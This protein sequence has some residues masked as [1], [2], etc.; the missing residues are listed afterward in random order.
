MHLMTQVRRIGFR[1]GF[2]A[3]LTVAMLVPGACPAQVPGNG[4]VEVV[5]IVPHGKDVN[6]LVLSQDGQLVLTGSDDKTANLWLARS[7]QLI[8]SFDHGSEVRGVGF[9]PDGKRIL[10]A[11]SDGAIKLWDAATA[12]VITTFIGHGAVSLNKYAMAFSS[13]GSRLVSASLDDSIR[14]WDVASGRMIKSVDTKHLAMHRIFREYRRQ[15]LQEVTISPDGERV[16][17]SSGYFGQEDFAIRLWDVSAGSVVREFRQHSKRITSVTS[18]ADM[19]VI[20]S[21]SEDN[22]MI[23]WDGRTGRPV[24]TVPHRGG[25]S[26]G[27]ALSFDGR[28]AFTSDDRQIAVWDTASGTLLREFKIPNVARLAVA[29]EGGTGFAMNYLSSLISFDLVSGAIKSERT[30]AKSLEAARFSDDG[31]TF[32]TGATDDRIR[33]W[34]AASGQ[35]EQ[36]VGHSYRHMS[37]AGSGPHVVGDDAADGQK[38]FKIF[39]VTTGGLVRSLT[40]SNYVGGLAIS[41]D[42]RRIASIAGGKALSFWD[43]ASGRLVRNVTASKEDFE[44]IAMSRDGKFVLSATNPLPPFG[45]PLNGPKPPPPR[46]KL[47]LWDFATGRL[48]RAFSGHQ[49][50]IWSIAFSNDGKRIVSGNSNGLAYLWD[51]STGRL[52]HTFTGHRDS[53]FSVALSANG[54]R[55]VTGGMDSSVK[56][57]DS[58]SGRLL[59]TFEGHKGWVSGVGLSPDGRRIL[60]ASWDGTARIWNAAT[61]ELLATFVGKGDDEW[62]VMTPE[63]FFNASERG[64]GLVS[65]VQ[66]LS[67]WSTEQFYQS[68]YRPDL[69]REKLAGDP[70]G[71][72]RQA[73]SRLDLNRL[74]ASGEVPLITVVTPR[75]GEQFGKESAVIHAD[76]HPRS[77]GLG[78]VEWRLNGVTV[79]IDDLSTQ[80]R[81]GSANAAPRRLSRTLPI[82]QGEN[83]IEIVAYNHANLVASRPAR[84]RIAGV[85]SSSIPSRLF[86]LAAGLNAYADPKLTLRN[87]VSDADALAA[88]LKKTGSGIYSEVNVTVL[89]DADVRDQGLAA[90]FADLS[91]RIRPTDVFVFFI[92]GHGKTIDGRYFFIPQDMKL[93]G[94]ESVIRHGIGQDQWQRWF[95]SIPARRSLLMFDTC[96]SGTLT[97]DATDTQALGRTAASARL[98]QAIG[99]TI[100]TASSG[101][102]DALEGYRGHGL[103][104]YSVLEGLGHAD[105]DAD[106]KIDIGE[107]AIYVHVNVATLSDRVFGQRQRPQVRITSSNFTLAAAGSVLADEEPRSA[108]VRNATHKLGVEAD[109]RV[110]PSPEARRLRRLAAETPVSILS[111]ER[112]WTLVARE[113]RTLGFVASRE[114]LPLR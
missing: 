89:K 46:G 55:T 18:S 38:L 84:L 24:H 42:G 49:T 37:Y 94:M 101:D 111:A 20:V 39:D 68:L 4:P 104:T 56:L 21:A 62:L 36:I 47:E 52:L 53:V 114:L 17:T 26:L 109:V 2:L 100:M 40:G 92:A 58:T 99:R 23:I 69:V 75:E 112:G 61:G 64:A 59:R 50:G 11:G 10:T 27:V 7:G 15:P 5:P 71:L 78:R 85:G 9:A 80:T 73:A 86:V 29:R 45:A 3:I 93:D 19:A 108:A 90:A 107:L 8:R 98:V 60:S 66:G 63:G 57:W 33:R 51:A 87:A 16:L 34:D 6:C 106:G 67:V 43:A 103:F 65:V 79:G 14:V 77:G 76:I 95:A 110:Q 70:R 25:W 48:V 82:E 41:A 1:A 105:S 30:V 91:N 102:A 81:Q 31:L 13:D 72:V 12:R 32:T 54:D 96:E 74:L 35:L 113:G 22:T 97:D 44:S 88:A 28:T 83:E